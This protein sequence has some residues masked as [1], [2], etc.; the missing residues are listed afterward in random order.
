MRV[1]SD[2]DFVSDVYHRFYCIFEEIDEK[3]SN[4]Q[5]ARN[6]GDATVDIELVSY[7][8]SY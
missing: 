5:M 8:L 7:G 1:K 3:P 4:Q 2:C 6:F